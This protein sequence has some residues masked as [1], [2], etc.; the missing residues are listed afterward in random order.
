MGK[1]TRKDFFRFVLLRMGRKMGSRESWEEKW[2]VRGIWKRVTW[3]GVGMCG[4]GKWEKD[5]PP[6]LYI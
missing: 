4:E 6:C 2:L 5:F 3:E 1:V